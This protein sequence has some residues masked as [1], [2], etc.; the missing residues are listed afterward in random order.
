MKNELLFISNCF[1]IYYNKQSPEKIDELTKKGLNWV[2]ILKKLVQSDIAP[3]AFHNLSGLKNNKIPSWFI[4][5]LKNEYEATLASNLFAWQTL[6]GMLQ[7]FSENKISVMGLKGIFMSDMLYKNIGLRPMDDIDLMARKQDMADINNLL[8]ADGYSI[9]AEH[10]GEI[11]YIKNNAASGNHDKIAV[12]IS[13]CLSLPRKKNISAEFLWNKAQK[14][15]LNGFEILYPSI[16]NGV[17]CAALHFFHHISDAFLRDSPPSHIKSILDIHEMLSKKQNEIDWAYLL[18]FSRKYKI[19][20]ILYLSLTLSKI[21]FNT[22]VPAEVFNKIK[23]SFIRDKILRILIKKYAFIQPN[24]FHVYA[25]Y[26]YFLLLRKYIKHKKL[27]V[28]SILSFEIAVFLML[29]WLLLFFS[30]LFFIH[31][32]DEK[33]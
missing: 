19:R 21:Y 22:P 1:N 13:C 20:H 25:E 24:Y 11:V 30:D 26:D 15:E 4:E 18:E 29:R 27:K 10:I 2:F 14:K 28:F 32:R 17:I 31:R 3:L 9:A 23:P 16:E 12:E 8:L 7:L 6:S 5:K 33:C